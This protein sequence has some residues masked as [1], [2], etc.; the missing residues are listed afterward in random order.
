MAREAKAQLQEKLE[1]EHKEQTVKT[2]KAERRRFA[3]I[4]SFVLR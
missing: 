2:G 4:D 3:R 1:N